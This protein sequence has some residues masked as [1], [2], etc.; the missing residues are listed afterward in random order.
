VTG[1]LSS[2]ISKSPIT[3]VSTHT[4]T[5]KAHSVASIPLQVIS[6]GGVKPSTTNL[7]DENDSSLQMTV[8]S[9]PIY[10]QSVNK[11]VS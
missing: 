4:A 5:T 11:Y 2:L 3:L 1:D 8:R 7:H 9:E 6:D 10:E